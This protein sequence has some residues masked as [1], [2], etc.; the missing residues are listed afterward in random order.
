MGLGGSPGEAVP[1]VV[2]GELT[3]HGIL[4]RVARDRRETNSRQDSPTASMGCAHNHRR[5]SFG[6]L[7]V[8]LHPQ[9]TWTSRVAEAV[10]KAVVEVREKWGDDAIEKAGLAAMPQRP[11]REP[12][13]RQSTSAS[14]T[15][16]NTASGTA[17]ATLPSRPASAS[18][19]LKP[20][21]EHH[22]DCPLWR[23]DL[24]GIDRLAGYWRNRPT[25]KRGGR[26]S[27]RYAKMMM[28]E[29]WRLLNWIDKQPRYNWTKPR[30]MEDISRKPVALP[31]DDGKH[32]TAFRSTTKQTYTPEQLAIIVH[33]CRRL[34]DGR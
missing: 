21:K 27:A 23:L 5:P 4:P 18:S 24:G 3:S 1:L 13:T 17:R 7:G 6:D 22:A 12:F 29:L 9:A 10:E 30:G 34:R 8:R 2:Y 31:E 33:A 19:G 11:H 16:G 14:P 32:E 25:T 20:C 28:Q 26:C 15:P